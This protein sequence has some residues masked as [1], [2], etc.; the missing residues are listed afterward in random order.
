MAGADVACIHVVVVEVLTAQ[1]AQSPHDAFS[2][3]DNN[4]S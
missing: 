3:H 2:M 4:R 1:E